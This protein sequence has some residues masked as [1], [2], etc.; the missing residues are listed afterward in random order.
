MKIKYART[1]EPTGN[2]EFSVQKDSV[3]MADAT[4]V[5]VRVLWFK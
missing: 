5:E 2:G 3:W 4:Y 1:V